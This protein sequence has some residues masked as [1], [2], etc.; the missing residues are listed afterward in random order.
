MLAKASECQR[1]LMETPCFVQ[2]HV[3]LCRLVTKRQEKHLVRSINSVIS[4]PLV[5]GVS[6]L[7][8]LAICVSKLSR[9]K[10][11]WSCSFQ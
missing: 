6:V 2:A 7:G 1:T 8:F 4:I 11:V 10:G 9:R 3:G 5:G